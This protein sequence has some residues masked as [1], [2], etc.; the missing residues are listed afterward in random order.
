M[1]RDKATLEEILYQ[2]LGL[3]F[4]QLGGRRVP[5]LYRTVID[6]VERALIRQALERTASQLGAADLLGIDRN[7][8]A[9]KAKRLKVPAPGS[10]S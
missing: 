8:L 4:E 5:H 6:Q 7:T 3:L 2:R 9:R 10:S 1:E